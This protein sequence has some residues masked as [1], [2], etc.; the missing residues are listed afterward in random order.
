MAKNLRALLILGLSLAVTGLAGA[1]QPLQPLVDATP[2]G[3]TLEP[4]PGV[5]AGPV[6]INKPMTLIGNRNVVIDNAGVGTNVIIEADG[7]TMDGLVLI[8]SGKLHH[9]IDSG[10]H[11]R[12]DYNV[13][14]NCLMENVLFGID[15][16]QSN[17]NVVKNNRITSLRGETGMRGDSIRLWYS[18]HN[19]ILDNVMTDARDMVVWY[20]ESNRIAGN[21]LARGRYGIHFMYSRYNLVEDNR[22]VDNSIGAYLMFSDGVEFRNNYIA[23][24]NGPSG[25]GIG[26]KEASRIKVDGNEILGNA[27]GIS[28]DVS[29]YQPDTVNS[30]RGNRI[31]F[32]AVGVAIINDWHGNEFERNDFK[33]NFT[34]VTVGGGGGALRH[35]WNDNFWDVYQGFDED[36][37]GRGDA[38]FELYSY[39]DRLWMD[40]IP[41]AFFRGSPILELVDF[42]ERLAPFSEPK[43]LVREKGPRIKRS[44]ALREML[45]SGAAAE[46]R[47]RN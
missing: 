42:L 25:I 18:M 5:Y 2:H 26:F 22:F 23:K 12:G 36:N 10:V 41:A 7:V 6:V 46:Q 8:N 38:P 34:Q 29:P 15:L 4:D 21:Y 44:D 30:I 19:K 1:V 43:L 28:I 32:N 17:N 24:S 11:I 16:Q 35:L 27:I 3:G 40:V 47:A 20:S 45:A 37:D 33:G 13:V 9:T 31:A 39:A 14:K